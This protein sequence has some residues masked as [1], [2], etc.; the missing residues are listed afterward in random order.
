MK[1]SIMIPTLY[2]RK[3]FYDKLKYKL[4]W[5]IKRFDL[6][7]EVEIVPCLDNGEQTI[8]WK[9]NYCGE[10]AQGLYRCFIDDDDDVSDNYISYLM[11]G[12]DSGCDVMSL[13]GLYIPNGLFDRPFLHSI[14]YT[15]AWQDDKFYYRAP[16]HLN[17]VKSEL[18]K[19]IKF[20]EKNF[21]EDGCWMEDVFALKRLKTEHEIPQLL[22]FYNA[23]AK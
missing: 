11:K 20:Q 10:Q 22:Y 5:Q 3:D 15:H 8:G 23:M 21:G 6:Y 2:S 4:D 18:V 14:K 13:I 1:L 12:I 9:R 17:C 16:N 7:N 19:D